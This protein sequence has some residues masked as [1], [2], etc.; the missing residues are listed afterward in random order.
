MKYFN[1]G[2]L[3]PE[4]R[5]RLRLAIQ[6]LGLWSLTVPEEFGGG[7]LDVITSCGGGRRVGWNIY[8]CGDG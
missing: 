4:E 7:G 8:P 3:T 2:E 1:T 5:S 6:Q